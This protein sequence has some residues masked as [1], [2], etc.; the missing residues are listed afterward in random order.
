MATNTAA[1]SEMSN[2]DFGL[3]FI[4]RHNILS[5]DNILHV[6]NAY[7]LPTVLDANKAATGFSLKRWRYQA[8]IPIV[9][10][11]HHQNILG[12]QSYGK[13]ISHQH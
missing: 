12:L 3:Y 13:F 10:K 6:C 8:P 9:L 4:A 5:M 2:T 7:V 1:D 11:Y